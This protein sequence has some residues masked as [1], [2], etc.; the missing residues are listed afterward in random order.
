MASLSEDNSTRGS[1]T[2]L[3]T[4]GSAALPKD[5]GPFPA[6]R[7]R[8][9]VIEPHADDAVLSVGG[10]M[11]LRR[12]ECAFAIATM[13]SRSNHTRYR[14]LGSHHD[15]KAVTDMRRA[16]SELAARALGGS[17]ICVGMTDAAL[18]YRD[19]EWSPEFY[20][21]HRVSISA[22]LARAPDAAELQ[23]WSEAVQ[24]L[25]R[26]QQPAEIWF[27]LGGPHA[28]H[29]L[30]ADAC[31][32]VFAADRSLVR[33]RVLRIYQEVPYAVRYPRHISSV[34][35][36]V[37]RCGALLE[38]EVVSIE[39]VR[40]EKR[41][42]A[43]LYGSQE[44]EQFF[45]AGGEL[46]ETFWRVRNLPRIAAAGI[47]AQAASAEP[48]AVRPLASWV[49]RNRNAAL[50]RVLL[51]TPTGRWQSD[52]ELLCRAFPH[53]RFEVWAARIAEAEVTEVAS[54]RVHVK[55]VGG[56]AGAWLLD[57]VRTALPHP[58]PTLLHA[59]AERVPGGRLLSSLWLGNDTAVVSSMDHLAA[60]L[61]SAAGEA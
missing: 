44:T 24:R 12:H 60:A 22:S 6:H 17:H 52:L 2:A 23:R 4:A 42:L 40:A 58:A 48:A 51:T 53:A 35:A 37:T 41:R 39:T 31:L 57:S 29:M 47:A 50:I 8:V 32:S 14:D 13:A 25:V 5:C 43:S 34:L 20:Q 26:E 3:L 15:I 11:W 49:A 55:I 56:G 27:P 54:E 19:T 16:E 21:R 7:R 1:P 10:T 46:P 36:A 9:L 59:S 38:K 28:D 61:R 33:D 30:T 18:R 45:G